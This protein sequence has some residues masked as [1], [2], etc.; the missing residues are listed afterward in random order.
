MLLLYL[1]LSDFSQDGITFTVKHG[2]KYHGQ[3]IRWKYKIL[4][5]KQQTRLQHS[6]LLWS[7]A[8]MNIEPDD[9]RENAD[10]D[11]LETCKIV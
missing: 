2:K 1:S 8:C 5:G 9:D 4:A 3:Q 10:D 7:T 11:N 6:M